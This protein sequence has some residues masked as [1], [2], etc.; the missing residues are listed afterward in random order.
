MGEDDN[1][2]E[3]TVDSTDAEAAGSGGQEDEFSLLGI[4]DEGTA[5]VL[6]S[7]RPSPE[8]GEVLPLS[9]LDDETRRSLTAVLAP[10]ASAANLGVQ[11]GQGLSQVQ[12]LVRLAPET[13]SALRAGAQPLTEGS[14]KL[15]TLMRDGKFAHQVRWAPAGGAKAVSA[16][17]AMGPAV[18]MLMTQYQLGQITKLVEKN[19]GLTNEVLVA[20]RGEQWAEV[21]ACH[22]AVWAELEN[23][24]AIGAVTDPV[25]QHVQAQAAETLL[26]KHRALY[27]DRVRSHLEQ[28]LS[29]RRATD[30]RGWI[31]ANAEF[32]LQDLDA[33]LLAQRAWFVYQALRAGHLMTAAKGDPQ[34]AALQAKIVQDAGRE[35]DESLEVARA[36]SAALYRHFSLMAATPGGVG[37]KVRGRRRLPADVAEAARSISAQVAQLAGEMVLSDP[38]PPSPTVGWTNVTKG[39]TKLQEVLRWVLEPQERLLL[40][41]YGSASFW[42]WRTDGYVAFTNHRVLFGKEPYLLRDG[43]VDR[44]ISLNSVTEARVASGTGA[45][46][47]PDLILVTDCRHHV[48]FRA[49]VA[50]SDL[51]TLCTTLN[52]LME[53]KALAAAS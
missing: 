14:W 34:A 7:G 35:H 38:A 51:V 37:L 24:R 22:D 11:L 23:A 47:G 53:S 42:G 21:H 39:R 18:T 15:G 32:V 43:N 12:G 29:K 50:P 17:A 31:T 30:R 44:E 40:A 27:L 1:D 41:T 26:R 6:G 9:L 49:E 13:L 48:Q 28:L 10:G 16:L 46:G 52:L 19:I 25:W 20:V 36:V 3:D 5:L 4:D 33:L 45:A 8:W 2:N